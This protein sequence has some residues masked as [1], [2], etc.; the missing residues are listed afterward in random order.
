M[1]RL[2]LVVL[3]TDSFFFKTSVDAVACEPVQGIVR[4]VFANRGRLKHLSNP[5]LN[6]SSHSSYAQVVRF[7]HLPP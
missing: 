6:S 1:L 7:Q 4:L 3:L 5:G 2:L